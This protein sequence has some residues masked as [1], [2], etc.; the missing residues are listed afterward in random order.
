MISSEILHTNRNR[1]HHCFGHQIRS[2]HLR[3][4]VGDI[5]LHFLQKTSIKLLIEIPKKK[6]QISDYLNKSTS[7]LQIM[8]F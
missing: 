1:Q 2:V 6:F 8:F 5:M 3:N 7:G 4:Y